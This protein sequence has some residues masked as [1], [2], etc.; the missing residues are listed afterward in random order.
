MTHIDSECEKCPGPEKW[1]F[2]WKFFVDPNLKLVQI[3][4]VNPASFTFPFSNTLNA[5]L[6]CKNREL[7]PG[8]RPHN[9]IFGFFEVAL[10]QSETYPRL[11]L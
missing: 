4:T 2:F 8:T 10:N 11:D 6:K 3:C 7:F 1:Y 5:Q 9:R